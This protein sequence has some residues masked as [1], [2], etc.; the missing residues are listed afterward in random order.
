MDEKM[1]KCNYCSEEIQSEAIICKHCGK[2][3]KKKRD[4]AMHINILGS[5]FIICSLLL[6][7]VGFAVNFFVPMAGEISGNA[8]A[9]RITSIIGNSVGLLL[10]IFALPGFICGF[11]LL[12]KKSWSR[13]F[14]IIVCCL[15]LFSIPFG[16]AI[17]AYGLWILFRDE[18]I[19]LLSS[20]ANKENT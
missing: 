9:M 15:S 17:G 14:G 20:P 8:D 1:K 5:L 7:I 19:K 3:Q 18:S 12:K 13:M 10:F 6:I 2:K 4:M 11:G 16:T